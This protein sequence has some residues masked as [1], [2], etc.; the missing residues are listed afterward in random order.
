M[1]FSL[2]EMIDIYILD[3]SDIFLLTAR[4]YMAIYPDRGQHTCMPLF[5]CTKD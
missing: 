5:N 4:L 1:N 3:E 2:D